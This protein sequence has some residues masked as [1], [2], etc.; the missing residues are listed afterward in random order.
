MHFLKISLITLIFLSS[1][2]YAAGDITFSTEL[3]EGQKEENIT[4]AFD[5]GKTCE[6]HIK[7]GLFSPSK[8]SCKFQPTKKV[9]TFAI[10]GELRR[11]DYEETGIETLL[12]SGESF[13]LNIGDDFTELDNADNIDQ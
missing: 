7:S 2:A 8:D 6:L 12:G 4:L 9:H 5:T 3:G 13:I 10:K 1:T 11:V